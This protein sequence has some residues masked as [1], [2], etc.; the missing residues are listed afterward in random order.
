[1]NAES[2][3]SHSVVMIDVETVRPDAVS[4]AKGRLVLVDLAGSERLNKSGVSGERFVGTSLLARPVHF[5]RQ[6]MFET[7]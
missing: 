3:R 1:M 6:L 5:E 2:S 4:L 7:K